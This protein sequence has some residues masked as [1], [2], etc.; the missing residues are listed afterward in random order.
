M[1][2]M[3]QEYRNMSLKH[4][5]F[6][7][8]SLATAGMALVPMEAQAGGVNHADTWGKALG[9]RA[10]VSGQDCQ[11][12]IPQVQRPQGVGPVA[13]PQVGGGNFGNRGNS[14]NVARPF[15]GNF[16]GQS[17]DGLRGAGD[18]GLNVQ[19]PNGVNRNFGGGDN[20]NS[21]PVNAYRPNS[22]RLN[23]TRP[24]EDSNGGGAQA[25]R[26][27]FNVARPSSFNSESGAGKINAQR[28]VTF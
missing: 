8:S 18:M 26:P 24:G 22:S 19:R 5:M 10:T 16:G 11:V 25:A 6:L 14:I 3:A 13:V 9:D 23:V 17:V 20:G 15:S 27:E 21:G 7:T 12:Q 28:P 4:L 2:Q 1:P